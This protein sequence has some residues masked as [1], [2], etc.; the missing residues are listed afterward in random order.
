LALTAPQ[1]WS[2]IQLTNREQL[3]FAE[4]AHELRFEDAE[5]APVEPV[6]LLQ[7]N[8]RADVG[9]DTWT[10]FNRIQENVIK[11]G[12][13]GKRIDENGRARRVTTRPIKGIDQD[14]KLNRALFT[15]AAKMAE[16][17]TAA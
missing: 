7:T 5:N 3:A 6:K 2:Q 11:G 15:L 16:I 9:N 4:A 8:R 14:V 17:K 1:D 12:L 10:V 13:H